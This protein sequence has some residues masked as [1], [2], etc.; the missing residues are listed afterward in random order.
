[1]INNVNS[2]ENQVLRVVV[3]NAFTLCSWGEKWGMDGY[4]KLIRGKDKC[5]IQQQ[6]SSAILMQQP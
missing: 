3:M 4:F 1:M 6:V 2:V 5:G